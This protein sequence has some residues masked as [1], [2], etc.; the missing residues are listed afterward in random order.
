MSDMY[1]NT[2]IAQNDKI[3]CILGATKDWAFAAANVI[4]GIE[5]YSPNFIDTI[6]LYNDGFSENDAAAIKKISGKVIMKDYSLDYFLSRTSLAL[7]E[8]ITNKT[9]RFSLITFARYEIFDLLSEF[10]ACLWIDCDTLIVG[11]LSELK[12]FGPISMWKEGTS[13]RSAVGSHINYINDEQCCFNTGLIYITRELNN[14]HTFTNQCYE[15][16]EKYFNTLIL[17]DQ[18]IIN[19]ILAKNNVE[20]YKLET[21]YNCSARSHLSNS[22][23]VIHALGLHKFWNNAFLRIA[24]PEWTENYNVFIANGGT[25]Y[26]GEIRFKNFAPA[27]RGGLFQLL[28]HTH[29]IFTMYEEIKIALPEIYFVDF[30]FNRNLLILRPKHNPTGYSIALQRIRY[31]SSVS[32]TIEYNYISRFLQK[33][34][35]HDLPYKQ[36]KKDGENSVTYECDVKDLAKILI[37]ITNNILEAE[38]DATHTAHCQNENP[39]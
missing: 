31:N 39:R 14:W 28:N 10:S 32:I 17:P 1:E 33:T 13:I 29:L 24:Y 26:T 6:I 15:A 5:K 36:T 38:A 25:P 9:N 37:S 27:P 4:S 7:K 34:H 21:K 30:I 19:L 35:L 22:A 20:P 23:V 16:T 11:D 12:S 3:A 18:G 8:S 2:P